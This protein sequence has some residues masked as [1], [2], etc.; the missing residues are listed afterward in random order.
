[1]YHIFRTFFPYFTD[2]YTVVPTVKCSSHS[3]NYDT[4]KE[5]HQH[6]SL[7]SKCVAVLA[8]NYQRKFRLCYDGSNAYINNRETISM[9][10][11]NGGRYS[12]KYRFAAC[13]NQNIVYK[14]ML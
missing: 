2:D 1:M 4:E 12:L 8:D 9:H 7:D 10:K 14:H 5:A 13:L 6:C 3:K 11:K